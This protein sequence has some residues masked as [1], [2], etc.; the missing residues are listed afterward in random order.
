MSASDPECGYQSIKNNVSVHEKSNS[1][2]DRLRCKMVNNFHY[3]FMFFAQSTN[4]DKYDW[5]TRL[6]FP[7]GIKS[8]EVCQFIW[9]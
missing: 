5:I 6:H 1:K 7:P 9:A 8:I 4:C 2:I 3:V